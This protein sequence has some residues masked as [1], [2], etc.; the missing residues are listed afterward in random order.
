MPKIDVD[1]IVPSNATGYPAPFDALMAKRWYRRLARI[2]GLTDFTASHVTLEPGGWSSQR[3]WHALEDEM[4]VMVAGEAVLIEDGGR[5]VMRPGDIAIWPK[6]IENGHHL[7]N[8]SDQPCSFVVMGGGIAGD[9]GGYSDI[10][11]LFTPVGY[12]RK[13]GTPYD[14]KRMTADI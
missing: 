8:E 2:G 3:H 4:L 9:H 5:Q 7:I 11:M 12:T 10:D 1:A 6:G 13:D 14:A